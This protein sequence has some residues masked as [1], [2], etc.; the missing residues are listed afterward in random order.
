[1]FLMLASFGKSRV[2]GICVAVVALVAVWSS[3]APVAKADPTGGFIAVINNDGTFADSRRT[4]QYFA[5]DDFVEGMIQTAT[6]LF[7]VFVGWDDPLA[8]PN[9]SNFEDIE[10]ITV[11][12]AT[13]DT[14]ILAFDST[15]AGAVGTVNS[16]GET[17]GTFDL[18][19]VPFS[20]V[21]N[22]WDTN[23][24]GH[25]VRTETLVKGPA[26]HSDSAN[27]NNIDYVTYGA[28][29]EHSAL[30]GQFSTSHSNQVILPGAAVKIGEIARNDFTGTTDFFDFSLE[31]IDAQTLFLIDDALEATS[32]N[33]QNK[34]ND[35]AFRVV[36]QLATS[37]GA[38]DHSTLV[39]RG[40][41]PEN[42]NWDGGW[43][44]LT[45]ES[46]ESELTQLV[47]LDSVGHS[48]PMSMSQ[49]YDAGG[50]VRGFW[51]TE[52]DFFTAPAVADYNENGVADAADY[53]VWRDN[54]GFTG[55]TPGEVPGDG[56]TTGDLDGIPDGNVTEDDFLFWRAH[57]GEG[58]QGTGDSVAFLTIDGS[59]N[60]TGYRTINDGSPNSFYT[61]SDDPA[62]SPFTF[63]GK[64]NN[65][66]VDQDTGDLIIVESGFFDNDDTGDG[67]HDVDQEPG[68]LRVSVDY[69][70]AGEIVL[71]TWEDKVFLD[72][73]KDPG[74][75]GVAF[76]S[77]STYDSV[78]DKVYFFQ[79]GFGSETP[80]YV[81]DLH[82]LD[83]TTGLTESYLNVVTDLL[84]FP[85]SFDDDVAF[86]TLGGIGAGSG[87]AAVP[88][89]ASLALL[90]MG[91]IGL[92][93]VGRRR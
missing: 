3:L 11:D 50:G 68:V 18:Y 59:G 33:P 8:S 81:T 20:T 19:K 78:N 35:H 62:T 88:E 44:R 40:G 39:D 84:V 5:A 67:L 70:D 56:T 15:S 36:R 66:F 16:N 57:F 25:D 87:A 12:P 73:D 69:D 6:P 14:Y 82:V 80:S 48:E 37:P 1:M 76:G 45:T 58:A 89:P 55:G 52:R 42:D 38:A 24:R 61:I 34:E 2:P 64:A 60:A 43:D 83:L 41:P 71:G 77:Y 30:A 23:Y 22:D 85:G 29:P 65:V 90:A 10:A 79:P 13:G 75:T 7:S 27:V 86:F 28:G 9:P 51:V 91:L 93:G 53:T 17:N 74:A 47:N 26:P 54:L 92:W 46:W 72:P 31:F 63:D 49:L 32:T 4:V 21:Y